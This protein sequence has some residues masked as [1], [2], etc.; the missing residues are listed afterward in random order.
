MDRV[1]TEMDCANQIK[2][3]REFAGAICNHDVKSSMIIESLV[4]SNTIL[5]EIVEQL[6]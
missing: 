5:F 3:A 2:A 6:K 1:L 4:T